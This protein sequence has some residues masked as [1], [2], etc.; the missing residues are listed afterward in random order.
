M[1]EDAK[2]WLTMARKIALPVGFV[3]GIVVLWEWVVTRAGVSPAI[4]AAPSAVEAVLV[5]HS[6]LLMKHLWPTAREAVAGFALAAVAGVILGTLLAALPLARRALYPHVVAFQLIPKVALAPLFILWFGIGS[7]ARLVFVMFMAFFPVVVSTISGI[8]G[9]PAGALQ[10]GRALGCSPWKQLTHIR[11]P[12][13]VPQIF[14]G[15]KVSVT[16]AII[17]TVIAEFITA[18]EGLG[19]LII[20]GSS[21]GQSAI[22]FAAMTLL[23]GLGLLLFAAVAASDRLARARWTGTA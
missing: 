17:G 11:L 8:A 6:A 14:A 22:V 2:P 12:Y 19:F 21:N 7:E 9:T 18:Q 10:L 23:S 1:G 13:A 4:L 5:D 16:M 15:L 3:I 20:M